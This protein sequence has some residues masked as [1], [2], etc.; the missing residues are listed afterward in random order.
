MRYGMTIFNY[1][2]LEADELWGVIWGRYIYLD[3]SVS[4]SALGFESRVIAQL[5]RWNL[6]GSPARRLNTLGRLP[7]RGSLSRPSI[8][9]IALSIPVPAEV[10]IVGQQNICGDARR[11]RLDS[12]VAVRGAALFSTPARRERQREPGAKTGSGYAKTENLKAANPDRH[13]YLKW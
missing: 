10:A 13:I 11:Q 1:D 12:G 3:H 2:A 7:P 6:L 8:I 4:L 9:P 5:A